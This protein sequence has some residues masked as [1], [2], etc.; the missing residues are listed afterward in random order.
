M[1]YLF[2]K[3]RTIA[4]SNQFY[5]G[6]EC[7]YFDSQDNQIF[8]PFDIIDVRLWHPPNLKLVPWYAKIHVWLLGRSCEGNFSRL[9]C[10]INIYYDFSRR[11]RFY[12]S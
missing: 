4:P 8:P 7:I 3:L 1:K 12:F 10:W 5:F 2:H 9:E 11:I 6:K